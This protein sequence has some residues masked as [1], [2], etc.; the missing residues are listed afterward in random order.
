MLYN[1]TYLHTCIL[2]IC[3]I[4]VSLPS[5]NYGLIFSNVWCIMNFVEDVLKGED[6]IVNCWLK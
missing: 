5:H 6:L 2:Y 3:I 4:E 1:V